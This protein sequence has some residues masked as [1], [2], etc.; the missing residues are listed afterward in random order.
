MGGRI[1]PGF[2]DGVTNRHNSLLGAQID[3]LTSRPTSVLGVQVESRVSSRQNSLLGAQPQQ[4]QHDINANSRPNSVSGTPHESRTSSRQNSLL[5]LQQQQYLDANR[6]PIPPGSNVTSRKGSASRKQS[7]PLLQDES[8]SSSPPPSDVLTSELP[9]MLLE[10][11]DV[12]GARKCQQRIAWAKKNLKL[13]LLGTASTPPPTPCNSPVSR[14]QVVSL[15]LESIDL[16]ELIEAKQTALGMLKGVKA[17]KALRA[18]LDITCSNDT[19]SSSSSTNPSG[20]SPPYSTSASPVL[21]ACT[22]PTGASSPVLSGTRGQAFAL[23]P[24]LPLPAPMDEP[25]PTPPCVSGN[26]V[27]QGRWVLAH[28]AKPAFSFRPTAPEFVPLDA[29]RPK[30]RRRRA[31]H[32]SLS[33]DGPRR[34]PTELAPFVDLHILKVY[35]YLKRLRE[36]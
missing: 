14:T 6:L 7:D 19:S 13:V 21:S 31:G 22:S 36:G 20:S 2:G 9:A 16:M 15:G 18:V 33:M 26:L 11:K 1:P 4:Q 17:A 5:G 34:D 25:L 12:G 23:P 8:S 3:S 30:S 10:F 24:P 28:K 29:D 27:Q 35:T 32:Q